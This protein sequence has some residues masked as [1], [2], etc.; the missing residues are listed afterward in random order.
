MSSFATDD[1]ASRLCNDDDISCGLCCSEIFLTTDP[2]V[3]RTKYVATD[4]YDAGDD[5]H[6]HLSPE[7]RQRLEQ[8]GQLSAPYRRP[9]SKG[10]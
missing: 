4:C 2:A 5:V 9:E 1:S 10:R 3:A 8:Q 7:D 6:S